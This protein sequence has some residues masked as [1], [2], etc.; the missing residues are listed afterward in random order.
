MNTNTILKITTLCVICAATMVA[1]CLETTTETYR[2]TQTYDHVSSIVTTDLDYYDDG[3]HYVGQEVRHDGE[4]IRLNCRVSGYIDGLY[5]VGT[6]TQQGISEP[7]VDL[8]VDG[9]K[10]GTLW[11]TNRIT[12]TMR[13]PASNVR[14]EFTE[15]RTLGDNTDVTYIDMS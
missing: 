8:A 9:S 13:G 12:G 7:Y 5:V 15:H 4:L 2:G 11:G 14:C 1:G 10:D 3:L 6:I